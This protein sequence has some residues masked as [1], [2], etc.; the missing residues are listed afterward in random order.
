MKDNH[1]PLHTPLPW[2]IGKKACYDLTIWGHN[3]KT[4]PVAL[5]PKGGRISEERDANAAYIVKA[6]NAHPKLVKA[7]KTLIDGE[8]LGCQYA[9]ALAL[10]ASLGELEPKE[11][12]DDPATVA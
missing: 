11:D 3:R 5:V 8:K 1:S 7:L 2:N 9:E 4:I 10:L 12:A 6:C